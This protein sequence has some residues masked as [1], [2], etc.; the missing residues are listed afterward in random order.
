MQGNVG[1]Y[2][3]LSAFSG[4]AL[5]SLVLACSAPPP[6]G[7]DSQE[8]EDKSGGDDKST[9]TSTS[10]S[11][12]PSTPATSTTP[13]AAPSATVAPVPAT[14]ATPP[15]PT[16]NTCQTADDLGQ[17]NADDGNGKLTASGTCPKFVKLRAV[18]S[19][20]GFFGSPM[21]LKVT[22]VSPPGADFDLAVFMNRNQ[23]VQDCG[24][25]AIAV[26]ETSN[27]QDQVDFSWGETSFAANDADDSRTVT[28][29]VKS[30]GG[31]CSTQPWQLTV[32][33]N[34]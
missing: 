24:P 22:L 2:R 30:A 11:T 26:S 1:M 23:D 13:P 27:P 15:A 14:P 7:I 19:D 25:L 9:N 5:A 3:L 16:T 29:Q 12:K 31:A 4:F 28:V 21:T 18:E 20:S 8:P 17:V 32:E 33:G 10:T 6:P 34:K